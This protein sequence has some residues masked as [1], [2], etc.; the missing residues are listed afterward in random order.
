MIRWIALATPIVLFAAACSSSADAPSGVPTSIDAEGSAS[1]VATSTTVA[2]TGE[3]AAPSPQ[4]KT[5]EYKVVSVA[6]GE[7]IVIAPD[8]LNHDD[9]ADLGQ[10]LRSYAAATGAQSLPVFSDGRAVVVRDLVLRDEANAD[11]REMYD[12]NFIGTY[13]KNEASGFDAFNYCLGGLPL[14]VDCRTI[15]Y[16][17]Y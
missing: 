2:P 15:D 8:V 9:M 16:F 17:D 4:P 14:Q 12:R 11:D 1:P 5:I 3:A 10:E 13:R 7:A 6:D